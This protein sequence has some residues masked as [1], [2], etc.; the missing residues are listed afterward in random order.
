VDRTHVL[1]SGVLQLRIDPWA[2]EYGSAIRTDEEDDESAAEVNPFVETTDWQPV[3]PAPVPRPDAILFVDGVQRI[4]ARVLAELDGVLTYGAFA[5]I[6]VGAVRATVD[7]TAVVRT[8]VARVLALTG[9]AAGEPVAVS[10]GSAELT[11]APYWSTRQGY[12]GVAEAIDSKRRELERELG[13]ALVAEGEPLVVLDGRLRLFPTQETAV[14]GLAKT[15]H[16]QYLPSQQATLLPQLGPSQRCPIFTIE[17]QGSL[18]SWYVRLASGRRIDHPLAGFVRLETPAA[19]GLAEAVRLADQT[20][21][22]LP[23]FAST[24]ERDSRAPQNLL[25]IGGL[26]VQLRHDMGDHTWV[27]RSIESH[28]YATAA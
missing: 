7:S 16:R 4:E 20:A 23:S 19:I 26:E 22:C 18:Y 2:T 24:P 9:T 12:L 11:F 5:S 21:V 17:Q 1:R 28:L 14:V 25:P 8:N 6:A 3:T 13:Q 15:I 10:C 27:R